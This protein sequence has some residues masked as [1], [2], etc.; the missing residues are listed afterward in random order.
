MFA[1]DV[2]TY[3]DF[4][5][6]SVGLCSATN[7]TTA[8]SYLCVNTVYLL[9]GLSGIITLEY[10]PDSKELARCLKHKLNIM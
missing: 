1:V 3:K 5:R 10:N 9:S 8:N 7:V 6:I 4:K 2:F